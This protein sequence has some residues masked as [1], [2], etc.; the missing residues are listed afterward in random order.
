MITDNMDDLTLI[1]FSFLL[2]GALEILLGLALMFD[3]I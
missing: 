2:T 1:L 3:K